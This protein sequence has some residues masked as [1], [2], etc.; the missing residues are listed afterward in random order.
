MQI[1]FETRL[2]DQLYSGDLYAHDSSHVH[3]RQRVISSHGDAQSG[4]FQHLL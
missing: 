4:G 2:A 3:A 1:S